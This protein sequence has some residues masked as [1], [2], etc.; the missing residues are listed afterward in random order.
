MSAEDAVTRTGSLTIHPSL[1]NRA[2]FVAD[3]RRIRRKVGSDKRTAQLAER[4]LKVRATQGEWLDIEQVKR[5]TFE[6]FCR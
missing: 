1:L 6:A 2:D 4:D 3:G 5:I